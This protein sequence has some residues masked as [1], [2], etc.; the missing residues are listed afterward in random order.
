[1]ARN[2]FKD[3]GTFFDTISRAHRAAGTYERLAT[4]SDRELARQG[5]SRSD[6]AEVALK[7]A[8]DR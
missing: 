4:M 7:S 2:V 6:L 5:Y 8:F 1:M 3:V